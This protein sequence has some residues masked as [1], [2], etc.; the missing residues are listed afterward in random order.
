MNIKL[1]KYKRIFHFLALVV[2]IIRGLGQIAEMPIFSL[3]PV[4]ALWGK[5][6]RS[7]SLRLL[8]QII[9]N[10]GV[11]NYPTKNRCRILTSPLFQRVVFPIS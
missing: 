9:N 7:F 10:L 4:D 6:F 11:K 5:G 1:F 8:Q 2:N 3:N